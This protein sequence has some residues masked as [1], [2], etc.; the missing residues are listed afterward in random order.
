[1]WRCE[2]MFTDQR[3]ELLRSYEKCDRVNEPDQTKND[4]ACQ[5][6][7][8]SAREK[9]SK[10]ILRIHRKDAAQRPTSG[11][12]RRTKSGQMAPSDWETPP[13]NCHRKSS[14]RQNLKR[15]CQEGE[16]KSR[17]TPN[18]FGAARPLYLADCELVFL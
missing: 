1:M 11:V 8:I 6:I 13:A 2:T 12:Q 10:K 18:A 5:P 14:E 7:G 17:P 15:S 16:L 3:N 9:F 4:K